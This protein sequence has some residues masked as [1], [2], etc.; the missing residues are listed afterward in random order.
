MDGYCWRLIVKRRKGFNPDQPRVPAGNPQGG[1]WMGNGVPGGQVVYTTARASTW[2]EIEKT[3]SLF[4]FG[5]GEAW[6]G[7]ERKIA[8][9]AMTELNEL[10]PFRHV[11]ELVKVSGDDV[12]FIAR[13]LGNG[14]V[15]VSQAFLTDSYLDTMNRQFGGRRGVLAHEIG[16]ELANILTREEQDGYSHLWVR[17]RD[18]WK[19]KHAEGTLGFAK[20]YSN[21]DEIVLRHWPSYQAMN[22]WHEDLAESYRIMIHSGGEMGELGQ[23]LGILR[24]AV[25]R[26][27][28]QR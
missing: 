1:Q 3:S 9:Q 18:D 16:H 2:E 6:T 20:D 10:K 17:T 21:Y 7:A 27:K 14:R 4:V 24:I 11:T 15:A 26:S 25:E 22:G 13:S 12:K 23:R 8:E 28:Q 19:K 5:E